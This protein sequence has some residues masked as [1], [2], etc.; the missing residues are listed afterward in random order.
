VPIPGTKRRTWLEQH[1]RALEVH[2]DAEDLTALD[3]LAERV[4]GSRY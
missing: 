2:L 3:P 1:I 4:V